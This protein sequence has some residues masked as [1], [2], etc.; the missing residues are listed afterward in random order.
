M[1]PIRFDKSIVL[2]RLESSKVTHWIR[3]VYCII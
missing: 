1:T 2:Y 3:D